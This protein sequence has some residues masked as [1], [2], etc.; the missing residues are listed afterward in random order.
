MPANTESG[1]PRWGVC[2]RCRRPAPPG[3][4]GSYRAGWIV[5]EGPDGRFLGMVC[6]RCRT[7]EEIAED[8]PDTIPGDWT[9]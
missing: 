3:G 6:P 1:D 4:T 2:A 7:D 9:P 8:W 5:H